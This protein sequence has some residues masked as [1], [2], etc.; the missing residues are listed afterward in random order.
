VAGLLELSPLAV[1]VRSQRLTSHIRVD[2]RLWHVR[3]HTAVTSSVAGGAQL[4]SA[5]RGRCLAHIGT[6]RQ[7]YTYFKNICSVGSTFIASLPVDVFEMDIIQVTAIRTVAF[8]EF[9]RDR[10]CCRMWNKP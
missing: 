8:W 6:A 1:K 3:V 10:N 7:L 4:Q 2:S 9:Q 5:R